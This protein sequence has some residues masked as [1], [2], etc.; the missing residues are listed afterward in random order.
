MSRAR[1]GVRVYVNQPNQ[2]AVSVELWECFPAGLIDSIGLLYSNLLSPALY[3]CI[4]H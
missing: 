3:A 1:Q 2:G 4:E